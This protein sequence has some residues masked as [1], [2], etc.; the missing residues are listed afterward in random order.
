VR[1]YK[2]NGLAKKL[3]VSVEQLDHAACTGEEIDGQL[4]ERKLDYAARFTGNPDQTHYVYRPMPPKGA[5]APQAAY[6][7]A[8]YKDRTEVWRGAFEEWIECWWHYE[9]TP[10]EALK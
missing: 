7:V 1:W 2:P 8:I 5:R 9:C 10:D 6:W 4:Y 3:K